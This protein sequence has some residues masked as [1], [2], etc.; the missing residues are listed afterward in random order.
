MSHQFLCERQL[1]ARS[2]SAVGPRVHTCTRAP[3]NRWM[4]NPVLPALKHSATQLPRAAG[5]NH[6]ARIRINKLPDLYNQPPRICISARRIDRS[7]GRARW[8]AA[9]ARAQA[10]A[11]PPPLID[12]SS[13]DKRDARNQQ[14]II[15]L[16]IEKLRK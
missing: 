12:L 8:I 1:T 13:F 6:A 11:S 16:I 10:S 3:S 7:P 4:D 14:L 5:I 9:R 2:A 15:E